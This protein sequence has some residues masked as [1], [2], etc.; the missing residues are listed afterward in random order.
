MAV[1]VSAENYRKLL[2]HLLDTKERQDL[3]VSKS[4]FLSLNLKIL[5]RNPILKLNDNY[6]SIRSVMTAN[7][8]KAHGQN[9]KAVLCQ[10]RWKPNHVERTDW[11]KCSHESPNFNPS[12]SNKKFANGQIIN[13]SKIRF[14]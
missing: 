14:Q 7:R 13:F 10:L 1:P 3:I 2:S 4:S 6:V 11:I 5:V 8:L 12:S 9:L